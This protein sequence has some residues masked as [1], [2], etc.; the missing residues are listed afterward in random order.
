[1]LRSTNKEAPAP[2]P[3]PPPPPAQGIV[4]DV[5]FQPAPP[6]PPLATTSIT[7]QGAFVIVVVSTRLPLE[8]YFFN[9]VQLVEVFHEIVYLYPELNSTFVESIYGELRL[10]N[11][12]RFGIGADPQAAAFSIF[13]ELDEFES[14]AEL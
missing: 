13:V 14:K 2:L 10:F 3:P 1:M 4:N 12:Q 11:P 7:K 5:F 9:S 6:S 8:L